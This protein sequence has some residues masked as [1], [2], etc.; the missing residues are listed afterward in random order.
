MMWESSQ[1]QHIDIATPSLANAAICEELFEMWSL[2]FL[3]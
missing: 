3:L 2:N 1:K